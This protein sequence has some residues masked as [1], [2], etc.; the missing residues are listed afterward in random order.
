[1]VRL[2]FLQDVHDQK[3]AVLPLKRN[4][5]FDDFLLKVK[6]RYSINPQQPVQLAID[7]PHNHIRSMEQLMQ[8]D[9]VSTVMVITQ[10]REP[11]SPLASPPCQP[12]ENSIDNNTRDVF[13]PAASY[14]PKAKA[15]TYLSPASQDAHRVDIDDSRN[16]RL[17]RWQPRPLKYRKRRGLIAAVYRFRKGRFFIPSLILAFIFLFALLFIRTSPQTDS[18]SALRRNMPRLIPHR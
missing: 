2:V 13:M 5:N 12:P 18:R 6:R 14:P 9:E 10:R 17:D 4:D 1:M 8:V 3:K 15:S 7:T 11:V 16:K